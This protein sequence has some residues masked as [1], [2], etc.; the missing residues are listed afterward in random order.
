MHPKRFSQ[1]KPR[2]LSADVSP[3]DGLDP[4]DFFRA[5]KS[6][7]K[8][9]RKSLQLCGQVADLLNQILCGE[10][11]DDVLRSLQ[12]VSVTPAP[13][14]GQLLVVVAQSPLD[15]PRSVVEI[16]ARLNRAAPTI[17]A[18]VAASVSRRR[19]PKLAFRVAIDPSAREERP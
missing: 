2:A 9:D 15:A 13:D 14:A 3:E 4:R 16:L 11:N 5:E 1:K 7:R 19:A 6:C 18:L 17:R 12:V 8:P 10:C